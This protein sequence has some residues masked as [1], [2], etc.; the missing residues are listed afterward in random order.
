MGAASGSYTTIAG[1]VR[2][3][4]EIERSR[5]ICVLERVDDEGAARRVVASVRAAEPKARHHCTAFVIGARGELA[6]SSDDGEPSGTAGQPMLEALRGEGLSDVAAVVS[7]YFGGVL[8]GTGGL[9]RAY[10]ASVQESARAATRLGRSLRTTL[11]VHVDYERGPSLEAELRRIGHVP[12][13]IEY[14]TGMRIDLGVPPSE[15]EGF[16]G[17]IAELTGGAARVSVAATGYVDDPA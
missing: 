14:G 1:R 9:V 13:R 6:R 4:L 8:L 7:R 11:E 10:T 2:T 16:A 3:E 5:F 12:L 15:T 17:R